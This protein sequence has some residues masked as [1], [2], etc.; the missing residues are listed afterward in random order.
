MYSPP[1]S[2]FEFIQRLSFD[3]IAMARLYRIDGTKD[4]LCFD[5]MLRELGATWKLIGAKYPIQS[6]D[7]RTMVLIGEPEHMVE[8]RLMNDMGEE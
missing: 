3:K 8:L 5:W 2:E 4:D 1:L 7:G 6:F